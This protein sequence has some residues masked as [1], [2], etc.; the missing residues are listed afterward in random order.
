M[1]DVP[2][3][4]GCAMPLNSVDDAPDSEGV[5]FLIQEAS[6]PGKLYIAVQGAMTNVAAAL[7]AAPEIAGN[8]VVL[9]NG[10]GPYPQGRP[11]F[12]T[13]RKNFPS[14]VDIS[15]NTGSFSA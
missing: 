3:L 10:G 12:N 15:Q 11:E 5:Q 6:K 1:D 7:N 14:S 8:I 9:W 13:R 4:R 2:C